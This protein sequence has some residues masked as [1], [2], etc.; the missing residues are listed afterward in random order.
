MI[1]ITRILGDTRENLNRFIGDLK[2]LIDLGRN[3]CEDTG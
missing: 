2:V 1:F 3:Q